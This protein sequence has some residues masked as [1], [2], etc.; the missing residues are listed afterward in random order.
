[1]LVDEH[2]TKSVIL[3][4]SSSSGCFVVISH[5]FQFVEFNTL[6]VCDMLLEIQPVLHMFH[7]VIY[8]SYY[9]CFINLSTKLNS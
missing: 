8:N 9:F 4:L 1:M 6:A 2:T 3:E 7:F 5:K